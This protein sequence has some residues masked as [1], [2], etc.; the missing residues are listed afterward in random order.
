MIIQALVAAAKA[1]AALPL[2]GTPA[3]ADRFYPGSAPDAPTYPL[4]IISKVGG[5]SESTLAG[6][7]DISRER[8]QVDVYAANYAQAVTIAKAFKTWIMQRPPVGD[9][10]VIDSVHCINDTDFPAGAP[11]GATER[12]GPRLRRR[13]LEFSVWN[14]A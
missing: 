4:V 13:L 5:P 9:A 2:L 8:I 6:A 10:C 7:I 12:A 3:L 14:R 11:F 1:D